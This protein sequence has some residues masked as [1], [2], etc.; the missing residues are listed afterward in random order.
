MKKT[1]AHRSGSLRP[2]VM[3]I[4]VWLVAVAGVAG[5]FYRR[6][7]RFEVLGVAQG[8]VRQVAA[9]C[10]GRLKSV[11]V[12]LFQEVR[13]GDPL[14]IIDTVLDSEHLEAE[15]SAASAEVQHLSAELEATRDRLVA[16]AANIETDSIAAQRRFYVDVENVR[17]QVLEL[18]AVVETD[19][20]MLEDL[21]LSSKI[22]AAQNALDHNDATLYG[23]KK[24]EVERAVLVK[25]IEENQ[26]LLAQ[27]QEDLKQAQLRRDEFAQRQPQ[28]PSIDRALEVA[29]RAINVQEQQV[30]VLLARRE[31][32]ILR[33][34][35]DGVVSQILRRP[36]R[37]TG[38]GVVRQMI[39][40][41][42]EAVLDGEPILTISATEPSEIIAY[43]GTGQVGLISQGTQV[44]LVKQ[45]EPPQIATSRVTYLGPIMEVKPQRLWIVP[46]IP[47]WGRPMLI[48]IPPGLKLIPGEV[49]GIKLM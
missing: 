40:R 28:L 29:K 4:L 30:A 43:I 48:D 26:R 36:V 33:A 34:P 49:V 12:E 32:L 7:Q 47:E 39:R 31:P 15:L 42:G 44:Q 37:R 20:M 2:H 23:R 45:S 10:T 38:E 21:E 11:P 41:A 35:I 46:N 18:K 9:T 5:L 16:E 6:A 3:P 22:F 19:R 8:Q 13:K 25:K 17:L 1:A 24:I 14:A 27:A